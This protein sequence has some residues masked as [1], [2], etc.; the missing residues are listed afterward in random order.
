MSR[1][2][3]VRTSQRA[4]KV[5]SDAE[6]GGPFVR[7]SALLFP[8]F[9]LR[10]CEDGIRWP[11]FPACLVVGRARGQNL[12]ARD[13]AAALFDDGKT[14]A[15]VF[16]TFAATRDEAELVH[17]KAADGGVSGVFGEGDVVLG[18]E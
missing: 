5:S 8:G 17:H 15:A 10:S 18:V 7:G 12:A 16:E 6:D 1:K 14:K 2:T 13:P 9:R 4:G 3:K 11:R